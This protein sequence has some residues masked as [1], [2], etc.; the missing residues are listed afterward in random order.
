MVTLS[1]DGPAAHSRES[2]KSS[3]Q[4]RKRVKADSPPAAALKSSRQSQ[5]R[6][7]TDTN[8]QPK[9]LQ[10]RACHPELTVDCLGNRASLTKRSSHSPH[11]PGTISLF[12][13]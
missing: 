7:P 4:Q 3:K 1:R 2:D 6:I 9:R 8:F 5:A 12:S 11:S 13:V 10:C